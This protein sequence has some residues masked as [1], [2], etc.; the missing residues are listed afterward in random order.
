[1]SLEAG[2]LKKSSY[3]NQCSTA[4]DGEGLVDWDASSSWRARYP[5]SWSEGDFKQRVQKSK[6]GTLVGFL[7][8]SDIVAFF[9]AIWIAQVLLWGAFHGSG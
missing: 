5:C 6:K 1:M 2:P 9:F 7:Q 3:A 4:R 8:I